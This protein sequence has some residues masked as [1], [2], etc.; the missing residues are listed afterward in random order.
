MRKKNKPQICSKILE[1]IVCQFVSPAIPFVFV[2]LETENFCGVAVW[3]VAW[4]G[5]RGVA[6][7]GHMDRPFAKKGNKL[8][9]MLSPKYSTAV[10]SIQH[11]LSFS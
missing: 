6:G 8:P 11:A 2:V 4:H 9:E 10:F 7:P 3:W 5:G 1:M